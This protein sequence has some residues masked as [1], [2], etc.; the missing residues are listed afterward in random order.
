MRKYICIEG[1]IG[2]GKTTL[3]E[4]LHSFLREK[5][6]LSSVIYEQFEKNRLLENFYKQ[7]NVYN[8]LAEY[9]FLI[10]RFH[11]LHQHFQNFNGGITIS[12]YCFKK[13]LWFAQNNLN[14]IQFEEYQKHYFQLEKDLGVY[15]DVIIFLDVKPHRAF[16]NIQKRNR[17]MEKNIDIH[18]LE[19][20]Y[21]IYTQHLQQDEKVIYLNFED[22]T[23]AFEKLKDVLK[24]QGI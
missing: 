1:I 4:R 18:Y 6:N 19:K 7:P 10:D 13:C 9:S 2:A 14:P 21:H 12:D 11:Q 17:I 16:Q 8:V 23:E 20:L 24:M 15:P 3:T 5:H 22:Y